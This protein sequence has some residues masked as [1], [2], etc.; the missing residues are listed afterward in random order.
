MSTCIITCTYIQVMKIA[1]E[2]RASMSLCEKLKVLFDDDGQYRHP[3]QG[4]ET[5]HQQMKHFHYIVSR[6]FIH[7]LCIYIIFSLLIHRSQSKKSLVKNASG[8]AGALNENV[9]PNRNVRI[10]Y[11]PILETLQV[12]LKNEVILA[13]VTQIS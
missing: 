6:V 13:E 9:L 8:K 1:K 11:I 7:M 12:L 2:E 4:L 5:Q 10:Y 3:F